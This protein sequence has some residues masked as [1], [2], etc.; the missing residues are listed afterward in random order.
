MRYPKLSPIPQD[1]VKREDIL[2]EGRP[3]TPAARM[4]STTPWSGGAAR[5]P[6]GTTDRP[7]AALCPVWARHGVGPESRS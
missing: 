6:C 4:S 3:P 7:A 5:T 2:R 1:P